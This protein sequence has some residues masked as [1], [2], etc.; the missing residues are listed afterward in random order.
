MDSFGVESNTERVNA[1]LILKEKT[2]NVDILELLQYL[3]CPEANY[4]SVMYLEASHCA[5][6]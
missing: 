2:E 6:C 3:Y 5:I 1:I 4:N